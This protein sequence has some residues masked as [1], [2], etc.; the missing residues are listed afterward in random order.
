MFVV[1]MQLVV[2]VD[3]RAIPEVLRELARVNFYTPINLTMDA[4]PP[5]PLQ[6]P[7]VYGP[8]PV[9][10]LTIDFEGY[11]LRSVFEKFIPEELKAILASPDARDSGQPEGGGAR[12]P[13]GG[14]E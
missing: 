5:D 11:F 7:Y 10:R 13:R 8:A 1:P 2:V 6:Q 4:L 12:G 3:V 14:R 9:A